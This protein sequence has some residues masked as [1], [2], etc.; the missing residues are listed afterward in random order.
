M[1]ILKIDNVGNKYW[2]NENNKLHREDG[3][4]IEYF[5]G[6]KVWYLNDILH[7]VDGPAIEDINGDKGWWINGKLHREEGPA[8][9]CADGTKEW[10]YHGEAIKCSS[11]KEF[12][13]IILLLIFE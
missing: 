5:H 12:E 4:A 8:L 1:S 6:T 7:R 11:Q 13:R 10:Y 2:H 9:E 3:P